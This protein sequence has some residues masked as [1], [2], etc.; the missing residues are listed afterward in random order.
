MRAMIIRSYGGPEVLELAEVPEPEVGPDDVLVRV[1]AAS[2]NPIDWKARSGGNRAIMRYTMPHVLGLD[3]S[4]VVEA[5]GSGVTDYAVGDEVW[6][7][8][9]H[10]RWGTYAERVA[11][12]QAEISHKPKSLSHQEAASLPLVA[13]TAWQC[14]LPRLAERPGQR[15]FIHAGSGGVGTVAIQLAK[16][17]GAWVATTCSA[18]NHDLV[19]SLGADEVID[20]TKEAF[21]DRLSDI[22]VILDSL[23]GEARDRSMKVLA[24]GGRIAS[25][26]GNLPKHTLKYGTAL[27]VAVLGVDLLTFVM[28]GKLR[29][30]DT[31][32]VL[33]RCDGQMLGQI[34]ELVDA[35]VIRP[36]IDR[37]WPMEEVAEAHRY[38]ETGH[39]RGKVVLEGFGQ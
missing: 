1:M 38:G 26:T 19:R 31:A 18:R 6:S 30:L 24:K 13:L 3:V 23:G 15:V 27:G 22:D 12:H 36:V 8:P 20:Y 10:K 14:L 7:S 5:V 39:I 16:H 33:K 37:T 9:S 35:G 21:E 34:A 29:G 4:G 17:H 25:I 11:I 28:R 32:N 2:I